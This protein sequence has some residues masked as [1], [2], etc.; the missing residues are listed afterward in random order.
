MIR[1]DTT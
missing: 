1:V